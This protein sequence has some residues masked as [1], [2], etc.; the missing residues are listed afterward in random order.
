VE[1]ILVLFGLIA[2]SVPATIAYLLWRQHDLR[3]KLLKLTELTMELNDGLRRDLLEL[4]RQVASAPESVVA[5]S[6]AEESHP[7][8]AL[9]QTPIEKP[10]ATVVPVSKPVEAPTVSAVPHEKPVT[11]VEKREAEALPVHPSP[12][13]AKPEQPVAEK[14]VAGPPNH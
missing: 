2:V 5:S 6:H 3:I 10:A 8:A 11:V 12:P 13:P 4:K 14:T 1:L 7:A 9:K